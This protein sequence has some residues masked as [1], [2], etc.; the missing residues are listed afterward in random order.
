MIDIEP[1]LPKK[2][3]ECPKSPLPEHNPV[4][5]DGVRH[6]KTGLDAF[7]NPTIL[8]IGQLMG[9]TNPDATIDLVE[10]LL[11]EVLTHFDRLRPKKGRRTKNTRWKSDV[12]QQRSY[13]VN[14]GVLLNFDTGE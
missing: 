4:D 6:Y 9:N 1:F 8:A 7:R 2:C 11:H 12:H 5:E 13:L 14:E 3:P 10:I